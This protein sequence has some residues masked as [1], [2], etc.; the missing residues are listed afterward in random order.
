M[1]KRDGMIIEVLSYVVLTLLTITMFYPFLN[2]LAVSFSDYS[3]YVMNPLMILPKNINL[4]AFEFVFTNPLIISSYKNTLVVT[5]IGTAISLILTIIT[6]YPLS[7]RKIMGRAVYMNMIIFTMIFYGGIIPNFLLIRSIGLYDSLWALILPGALSAFNILIM[8][9]FFEG[10]PEELEEAAK[11]DGASEIYILCRI[12]IPLSTPVIATIAL[13]Y[14]VGYW[15]SYFNAVMYIRDPH[16]WTLQLLL[17]EVVMSANTAMMQTAGN[18]AEMGNIPLKSVI[19]ATLV[20]V[21]LPILFLYPFLQRYF[22]KG[23]MLG[24]IKG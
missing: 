17:R 9:T 8:K 1:V 22:V 19:Y 21:M 12:V 16:K 7:K 4:A 6:A 5:V 13:F 20:I 3:A 14:A 24:A 15:N 10:L 2:V 11:I 18:S 23:I